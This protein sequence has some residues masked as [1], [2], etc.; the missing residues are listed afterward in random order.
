ML[1]YTVW[2]KPV[3]TEVIDES[4]KGLANFERLSEGE[5]VNTPLA[6]HEGTIKWFA[7]SEEEQADQFEKKLL[8][9]ETIVAYDCEESDED[10]EEPLLNVHDCNAE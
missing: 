10:G 7:I 4:Y 9:D 5:I 8:D 3:P 2:T 6:R 1:S